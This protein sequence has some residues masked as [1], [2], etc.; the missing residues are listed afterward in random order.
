M[1]LGLA[2]RWY[3]LPLLLL[4]SAGFAAA[5]ML[6]ALLTNSQCAWMALVGAAD[7]ALLQRLSGWP[8]GVCRAIWAGAAQALILIATNVLIAAG[9]IGQEMGLRPW[10]SALKIGADYAWLLI[11]MAT[12]HMDAALYGLSFVLVIWTGLS[13]RRPAPS[14]Q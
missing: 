2:P 12:S 6:L 1:L 5:W 13:G 3:A 7:I 10:E 9:H 4:G 14:A 11:R 8:Q